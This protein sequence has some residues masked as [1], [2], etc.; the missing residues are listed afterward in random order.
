MHYVYRVDVKPYLV[1]CRRVGIIGDD[2]LGR[3]GDY[4]STNVDPSNDSFW[5]SRKSSSMARRRL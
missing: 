1:V 2:W 5:R 3:S 4:S